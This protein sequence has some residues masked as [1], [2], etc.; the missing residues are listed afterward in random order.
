MYYGREQDRIW[1]GDRQTEAIGI[2]RRFVVRV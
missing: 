2:L 1:C